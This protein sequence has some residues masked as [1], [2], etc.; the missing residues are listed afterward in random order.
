[1]A[2]EIYIADHE[3]AELMDLARLF[4]SDDGYRVRV[5][6]AMTAAAEEIR[7]QIGSAEVLCVAM[8]EV[9]SEVMDAAPALRLIAKTGIG[10][11]NI[12]LEA[13]RDRGLS[14]IRT[15]NVNPEGVAEYLL[16][17]TIA[18][19]RR[20]GPMD[21]GLRSGR[22]DELRLTHS[23]LLPTITGR[24]I[25][26]LGFGSI[27]QRYASLLAPHG[28]E[29][30]ALDPYGSGDVAQ[31]MGVELVS[32]Q[33]FFARSEVVAIAAVLTPET[34]H[35]IGREELRA[36]P[37]HA[38]V[39]NAARGPIVDERALVEALETGDIAGAALDVFEVEPLAAESPLL[40]LDNVLLTPHLAGAT[41]HGFS[42]IGS[43]VF[44]LVKLVLGGVPIPADSVVVEGA[45]L[46]VA[47]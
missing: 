24:T 34:R 4:G 29:L 15:G 5:G 6:S 13:A 42:R 20:F 3:S 40:K 10:V 18:L 36:M 37:A 46:A 19:L 23:G 17:A 43:R 41:K 27:G 25:G 39:V 38:V 31:E 16:G 1:M 28:V 21:R 2:T 11:D 9:T 7:L 26:I 30:I 32:K 44:E 33:A 8:G 22:Y 45:G 47:R 12:D 35:L 14:V